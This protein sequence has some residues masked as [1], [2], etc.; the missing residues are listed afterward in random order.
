MDKNKF[1]AA[2]PARIMTVKWRSSHNWH[3]FRTKG[4][5]RREDSGDQIDK[6]PKLMEPPR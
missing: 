4:I 1:E 3:E 5:E 2:V 6:F